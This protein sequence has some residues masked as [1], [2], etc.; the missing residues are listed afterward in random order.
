MREA[1]WDEKKN[2]MKWTVPYFFSVV[3]VQ[4]KTW[5]RARAFRVGS[6]YRPYRP[7]DARV[8]EDD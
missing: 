3:L 1:G 4:E 2:E 6:V 5:P 8:V 7:E